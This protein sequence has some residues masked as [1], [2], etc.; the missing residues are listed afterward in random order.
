MEY[1][2]LSFNAEDARALQRKH[3]TDQTAIEL[4]KILAAIRRAAEIGNSHISYNTIC[5]SYHVRDAVFKL[6][7]QRFP[8]TT[9]IEDRRDGSYFSISW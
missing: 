3:E 6:L 4:C 1:G 5:I 2:D 7:I 9:F 8:T